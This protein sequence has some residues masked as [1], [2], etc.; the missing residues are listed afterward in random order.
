MVKKNSSGINKENI[1]VD[2]KT[3]RRENGML[4]YVYINSERFKMTC[5]LDLVQVKAKQCKSRNYL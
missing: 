4:S 1:L 2:W 5:H 3:K